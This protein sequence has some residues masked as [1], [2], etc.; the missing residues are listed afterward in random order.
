MDKKALQDQLDELSEAVVNLNTSAHDKE[1]LQALISSIEQQ[2]D[3]PAVDD[4]TGISDQI[5]DLVSYFEAEH[6]TVAGILNNLMVT[7]SSMG[8]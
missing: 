7:L 4:D 2:M 1:K 6:P 5:D 3:D 8:I